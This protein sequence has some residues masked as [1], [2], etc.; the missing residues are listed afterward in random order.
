MDLVIAPLGGALRAFWADSGMVVIGAP[1][2][3]DSDNQTLDAPQHAT[4]HQEA[5]HHSEPEHLGDFSVAQAMSWAATGIVSEASSQS[6]WSWLAASASA[7]ALWVVAGIDAV[8]LAAAALATIASVARITKDIKSGQFGLT[9][10][11]GRLFEIPSYLALIAIGGIIDIGL[12]V[13]AVVSA[14]SLIAT[15]VVI[16]FCATSSFRSI[17]FVLFGPDNRVE[18]FIFGLRK[19][20]SEVIKPPANN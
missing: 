16:P 13:P 12:Q 1:V 9:K 8:V 4:T 3:F 11:L 18:T 15:L 5:A 20:L 14:K 10:S 7:A 6:I 17:F 19:L 2:A